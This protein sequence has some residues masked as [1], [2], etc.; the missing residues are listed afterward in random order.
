MR[1]ELSTGALSVCGDVFGPT[2]PLS[3][4]DLAGARIVD[5]EQ[6]PEARIAGSIWGGGFAGYR[7]GWFKLA[8]GSKAQVF[9]RDGEGAVLIPTRRNYALLVSMPDPEAFLERL[10][11]RYSRSR[12]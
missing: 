12:D 3:Q 4:L 2:L 8:D 9:L 10:Q 11:R 6:D 5:P 1:I 7:S